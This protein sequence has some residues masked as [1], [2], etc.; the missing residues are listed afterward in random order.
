MSET[1]EIIKKPFIEILIFTSVQLAIFTSVGYSEEVLLPT[2]I[3]SI[4]NEKKELVLGITNSISTLGMCIFGL[5]SGIICDWFHLQYPI[6][7][8]G[9]ILFSITVLCRSFLVAPWWIIFPNCLL[10]II[11]KCLLGAAASAFASLVPKLFPKSQL[12]AAG[13]F[14]F[15]FILS[16]ELL[17]LSAIGYFFKFLSPVFWSGIN[18]V[19]ILSSFLPLFLT[20]IIDLMIISNHNKKLLSSINE[21][22]VITDDL[23]IDSNLYDYTNDKAREDNLPSNE[24]QINNIEEKKPSAY[25]LK[26][27]HLIL[28]HTINQYRFF[29]LFVIS[30]FLSVISYNLGLNYI[31]YFL[32]DIIAKDGDYHIIIPWIN[33]HIKDAVQARALIGVLLLTFSLVSSLSIGLFGQFIKRR[34]IVAIICIVVITISKA[35]NIFTLN[36]NFMILS[37]IFQGAATGIFNSISF[38]IVNE[39]LPNPNTSGRDLAIASFFGTSATIITSLLGGVILYISR[40]ITNFDL[41]GYYAIFVVATIFSIIAIILMTTI[42]FLQKNKKEIVLNPINININKDGLEDKDYDSL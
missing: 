25:N 9:T 19:I 12:G 28:R 18:C 15:F 13:G 38:A 16:G 11:G 22:D 4:V 39:L 40:Y 23:S 24:I 21:K 42:L 7:V 1:K 8:I 26:S 27:T 10:Q 6:I 33:D 35:I 5:I 41:M 32:E 30:H 20:K 3:K 17:A 2:Q 29:F 34:M 37:G 14:S 36:Y 31:L